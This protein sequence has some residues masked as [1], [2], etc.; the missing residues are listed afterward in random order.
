MSMLEVT[1]LVNK[2]DVYLRENTADVSLRYE[3]VSS[4][5]GCVIGT[6]LTIPATPVKNVRIHYH[7]QV[8]M[9]VTEY[10]DTINEAHPVDIDV[11]LEVAYLT[12]LDRY[13]IVHPSNMTMSEV[14]LRLDSTPREHKTTKES[15]S[16][17][18]IAGY[19]RQN[20]S[21]TLDSIV[22]ELLAQLRK[23]DEE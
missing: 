5:I 4:L 7:E 19:F 6:Q 3:A 9:I 22:H 11:A 8:Y 17:S 12:W 20:K 18:T 15:E 1:K 16:S 23:N 13:R 21:A 2:I 14:I 10:L